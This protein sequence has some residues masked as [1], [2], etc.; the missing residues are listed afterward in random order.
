MTDGYVGPDRRQGAAEPPGAYPWYVLP[1]LAGFVLLVFA[2]VAA[3]SFLTNDATLRTQTANTW[4]NLAIAVVAYWYGSSAGSSKKDDA[5]AAT[6]IKANETIAAQGA[7]LATS[8]PVPPTVTTTTINP[9]PPP[10]ATTTTAP[11]EPLT[12]GA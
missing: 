11:A 1:A 7:A 6:S 8:A 2:A 4:S 10:T 3:A 12:R 5:L 9:G